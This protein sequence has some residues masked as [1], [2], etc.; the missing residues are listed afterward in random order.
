[1]ERPIRSSLFP[2]PKLSPK[3]QRNKAIDLCSRSLAL[4]REREVHSLIQWA[5]ASLGA[6][7]TL[8]G[9]TAE[10]VARLEEAVEAGESTNS[11]NPFTLISLGQVYL[12]VGRLEEAARYAREALAL[13][14]HQTT[15]NMEAEALHLIGDLAAR[16]EP[17][18]LAEATQYDRQALALAEELSLHPL[19]AHCHLGLAQ[20]YRRTGSCQQAQEHLTTATTMYR[21]MGM[22]FWLEKAETEMTGL[23]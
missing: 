13:C 14:R 6:A 17:P 5:S 22:R 20:L 8:A 12:S 21:E 23:T 7:Y 15:R 11:R 2:N 3:G 18:A 10:A 1:M 16:R 4:A 9:R 19:V